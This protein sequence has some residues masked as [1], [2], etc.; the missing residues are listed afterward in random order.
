MA[1]SGPAHL[2]SAF[3]AGNVGTTFL[4]RQHG[5]TNHPSIYSSTAVSSTTEESSE[6]ATAE[7]TTTEA[8]VDYD[9]PEDAVI[10]IK[11][12]AMERLR[13]LKAKQADPKTALVLRMGVR[14]GGCS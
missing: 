13:E 11:P 8:P 4:S 1:L 9:T 7:G 3:T 12:P 10:Q 14:N 6:S 2:S 5:N